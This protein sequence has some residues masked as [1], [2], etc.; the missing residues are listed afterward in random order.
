MV[1]LGGLI[2]PATIDVDAVSVMLSGRPIGFHDGAGQFLRWPPP[3]RH[4]SRSVARE[5]RGRLLS[6]R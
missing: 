5:P 4:P 6:L 2:V 3:P 1:T